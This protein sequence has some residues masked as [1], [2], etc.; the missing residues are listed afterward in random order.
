MDK[1]ILKAL[2]RELRVSI[3]CTEPIA[4]AYAT[5]LA[6]KY[7]NGEGISSIQIYASKNILKNAM[8]VTIPGTSCTGIQ[9]AAALGAAVGDADKKLEVLH[10]LKNDS[11]KKAEEI[12]LKIDLNLSDSPIKFYIEVIMSNTD[13]KSRVIIENSHTNIT[14]IESDGK[15]IKKGV[16]QDEIVFN[17][18]LSLDAIYEF[19][20][21]VNLN[22]LE[23]VD[24]SIDKNMEICIEGLNNP[25][26]L[27]VGIL[28]NSKANNDTLKDTEA[29][30]VALTAAGVDAR[31]SGSTLPVISNSGSGN[32]G[33]SATIPV[34]I[35]GKKLG[36]NKDELLRAVTLSHLVTILIKSKFGRLSVLCGATVST[37]GACCGITYLLGGKK[38]EI[39]SSIQNMIGNVAG[40]LCDGAKPGCAMK[41]ATCTSAAIQSAQ[42]AIQGISI[43]SNQGIIETDVE[44]T[45]ENFCQLGN[46]GMGKANDMILDIM[47]NKS[48]N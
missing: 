27:Q 8:G 33:I 43:D 6:K 35:I 16:S 48:L 1:N 21:N 4:I 32:Q 22:E 10:D 5:S 19:V 41:I 2:K 31:M 12:V 34:V 47:L 20:L 7:L 26:G 29:Y 3:G 13:S 28:M 44:K 37:I 38:A 18:S 14:L 30:A 11:L 24:E 45:I 23:I 39:E 42:M 46:H 25:Y 36:I 9:L 40:I 17:E 15:I